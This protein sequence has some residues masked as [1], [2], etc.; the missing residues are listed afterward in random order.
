MANARRASRALDA[1]QGGERE[2]VSR[3]Q[4]VVREHPLLAVAGAMGVGA[5]LG[6]VLMRNVGRLVFVAA[7]SAVVSELWNAEGGLDVRGLIDRLSGVDPGDEEPKK[8]R[9]GLA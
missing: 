5:L 3:V 8:S 6:G 7:A 4:T 1:I 9:T 2:I